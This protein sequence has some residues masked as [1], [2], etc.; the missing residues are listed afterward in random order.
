MK[1]KIRKGDKVEVISGKPENKGIRGEVIKVLPDNEQVVVQG[2][3]LQTKHQR[4]V[5][6]Q[7]VHAGVAQDA[8]GGGVGVLLDEVAHLFECQAAGLGDAVGLKAG[9]LR[10]DMGVETAAGAGDGVGAL[11][12]ERAALARQGEGGAGDVVARR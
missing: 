6:A 1:T 12:A 11:G 10:A 7:H 3:N 8:Q 4:Q 9:V 2:V 5:Q